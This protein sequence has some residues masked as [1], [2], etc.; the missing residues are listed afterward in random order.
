[1]SRAYASRAQARSFQYALDRLQSLN[2]IAWVREPAAIHVT[3]GPG[4]VR[5]TG[6]LR[7]P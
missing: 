5:L 3:A 7:E 6:L 2:L 1:V 4:A